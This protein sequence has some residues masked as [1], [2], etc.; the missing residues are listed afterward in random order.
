MSGWMPAWI[1]SESNEIRFELKRFDIFTIFCLTLHFLSCFFILS[2]ACSVFTNFLLQFTSTWHIS[3][4]L[5][6][7]LTRIEKRWSHS[8]RIKKWTCNRMKFLFDISKRNHKTK[9]MPI[10]SISRSFVFHFNSEWMNG[11]PWRQFCQPQFEI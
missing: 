8:F 6:N 10:D 3:K 4:S 2:L 5:W 11:S 9:W 7:V 1:T